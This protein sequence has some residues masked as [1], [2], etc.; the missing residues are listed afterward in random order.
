MLVGYL[1]HRAMQA[2]LILWLL[3]TL[4]FFTARLKG[5]PVAVLVGGQVTA[6]DLDRLRHAYGLDQPIAKQYEKFLVG[7]VHLDFGE[8]IRT[9]QAALPM[10]MSRLG[11]T[12]KLVIPAL[13]LAVSLAIPI[14]TIAASYRGTFLDGAA[15]VGAVIGQS[16]PSFFLGV[17]LI[18]VFGVK[19]RWLPVIGGTSIRYLILPVVTLMGYPLARYTRVVRAQVSETMTADFIRTAHAKGLPFRVVMVRHVLKN[20]LLPVITLVGTDIGLMATAAIIVE[21]IFAIPG[22]GSLFLLSATAR[23]YPVI[24]ASGFVL[25]VSVLLS[26]M[27]VDLS[28]GFIDPRMRH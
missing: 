17:L 14:G 15:M 13:V 20:A 3:L 26:S 28:Y 27:V 2:M 11:P 1:V 16:V 6:T 21:A 23:D 4:L 10:V 22:F 8:S 18:L 12:L 25:G 7:V 19:L 24:E 9:H 5:D